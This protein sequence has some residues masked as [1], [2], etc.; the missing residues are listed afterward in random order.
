MEFPDTCWTVLAEAT[1]NGDDGGRNALDQLC[2]DYWQPVAVTIRKRGI[3]ADRAED[4]TQDFFL[5]LMQK[6]FF[7]RANPDRG[8][9]RSFMLT[10]LRMPRR[11]MKCHSIKRGLKTSLIVPSSVW[12]PIS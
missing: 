2:R 1:L 12:H 3:S 8:R 4:L 10:S 9:F 5:Q 11:I 6:S 7:K